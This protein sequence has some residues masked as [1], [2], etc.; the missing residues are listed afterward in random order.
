MEQKA[1]ETKEGEGLYPHY[2][3]ITK[4]NKHQSPETTD[5]E[6]AITQFKTFLSL[7]LYLHPGSFAT[8]NC[9]WENILGMSHTQNI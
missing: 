4:P 6:E 2:P 8:G 3:R 1:P 9:A 7:P 5:H